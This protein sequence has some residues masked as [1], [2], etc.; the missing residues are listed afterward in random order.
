M[1]SKHIVV[2]SLT[3]RGSHDVFS[4]VIIAFH[5]GYFLSVVLWNQASSSNGFRFRAI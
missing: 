1:G 4:H 5:I 3:F 2:A